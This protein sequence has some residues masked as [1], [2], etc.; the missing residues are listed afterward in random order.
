MAALDESPAL[1]STLRCRR[2]RPGCGATRRRP[3]PRP[4]FWPAPRSPSS[5]PGSAP[6]CRLRRGVA[7]PPGA[8]SRGRQHPHRPP[9]RGRGDAARCSFIS[10]TAAP[11]P[12]RRDASCWR[13]AVSTARRR[14]MTTPSFTS[15]RLLDFERRR[16]AARGRDR[17]RAA[18]RRVRSRSRRS[19]RPRPR[20]SCSRSGPMPKFWRCGSPM[21]CWRRGSNGRCRWRCWPPLCMHRSLRIDGRRPHPGDANW[22]LGCCAAYAR[23]AVA[24]CDLFAEL[25]RNSQKLLAVA[26]RLRAKGAGAVID[27]LHNE[28]A[29]PP[30]GPD[31]RA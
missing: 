29:V 7:A 15:P 9:R 3:K 17:E 21:R 14:S 10:V 20:A 1:K 31:R 11:M 24:A 30:S 23:A 5:M 22:M 25:Q 8:Q 4:P 28:D 16:G 2:F 26:P 18:A 6:T 13:G 27:K 19:P 12:V